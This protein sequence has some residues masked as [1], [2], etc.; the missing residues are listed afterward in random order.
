MSWEFL[1]PVYKDLELVEQGEP[2]RRG[3]RRFSRLV[4]GEGPPEKDATIER[5]NIC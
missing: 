3:A 4:A 2:L 5:C 1:N